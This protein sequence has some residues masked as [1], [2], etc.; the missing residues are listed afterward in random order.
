M[1]TRAGPDD[2]RHRL[3]DPDRSPARAR[4]T[5]RSSKSESLNFRSVHQSVVTGDN[6]DR[7]SAEAA[8]AALLLGDHEA[9][10]AETGPICSRDVGPVRPPAP[11]TSPASFAKR[12]TTSKHDPSKSRSDGTAGP[13]CRVGRPPAAVRAR[14]R[15][16]ACPA[17]AIAI[18]PN[19]RRLAPRVP[20]ADVPVHDDRRAEL[21][22]HGHR[23]RVRVG[24]LRP[25][26][27]WRTGK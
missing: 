16:P 12:D 5:R 24:R 18:A 19:G 22:R 27:F 6:C 23:R 15:A 3:G 1:K 9:G 4:S 13:R 2:H 8:A 14:R 20:V 26:G 7:V 17:Q 11:I 25:R 21:R 10:A